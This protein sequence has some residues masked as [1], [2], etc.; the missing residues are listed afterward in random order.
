M[1]K[2]LGL[3]FLLLLALVVA[4]YA[5]TADNT[6][7]T[8]SEIAASAFR[9]L[10]VNANVDVVLV[11]NDTLRKAYVEGDPNLVPGI[12]IT[13]ADGTMIIASSKNINYRGKVQVNIAVQELW[14]IEI[15]ANAGIVSFDQLHSPKL[16]VSINGFCDLHLK[17]NGKIFL[18]AED[19]Y[20]IKYQNKSKKKSNV[21][22]EGESEG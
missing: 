8:V 4:S 16:Y 18:D 5:Q 6:S 12:S 22:I 11:Q 13:V 1:K 19:G 14:K 15:N 9:K 10:V 7:Y 20:W 21:I 3:M 17:S 2:K